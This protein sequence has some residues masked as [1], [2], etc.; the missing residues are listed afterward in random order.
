MEKQLPSD[1]GAEQGLL[2]SCM[3]DTRIIGKIADIIT[4]E[5]FNSPA[6][7]DIWTTLVKMYFDKKPID[8]LT[9]TSELCASK[10]LDGIGGEHYITQIYTVV[11]SS[12]NWDEYLKTVSDCYLR[13]KIH[14]AAKRMAIDALDRTQDPEDIK[15]AASREITGMMT[16]KTESVH[17]AEVFNSRITAWEEAART[18]GAINRGH[19]SCFPK[20]NMSTRGFRPQTVHIVAGRAKQGK[21]TAALQMVTTPAIDKKVPIGIISLEMGAGELVDKITSCHAQIGMNDLRDGKLNRADFAK[22]SNF[23]AQGMKA[24]IHIVDEA[25]MT[26]NQ[27]RARARRLVAENKC[28]II[29]LD[30]AQLVTPSNMKESRER[31]VAEISRM[32]K[33]V[34]KELNV[35]VVL[36]AQLNEDNTIRESRTF[37]MDC[38]SLTKIMPVE[39]SDDP[40]AYVLHITHNRNGT[41][42]II[43]L[44]FHKHMARLEE[45][46]SEK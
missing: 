25:S 9:I 38:D 8:L 40:Y 42:P 44:R 10:L 35:C 15:E 2:C 45:S 14:F 46:A 43:P 26:V 41:T 23:M 20:W 36:L 6:H 33:I 19:D 24:P 5:H 30:Y 18:G 27:F 32:T 12:A 3:Q 16:T 29:M 39:E 4:L 34:A 11:Y 22:V 17:I 7:Q 28:E 37:E 31:Q 1:M 13:R 21:T